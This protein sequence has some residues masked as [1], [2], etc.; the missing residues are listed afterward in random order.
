M[1][2]LVN[3]ANASH[4]QDLSILQ[5]SSFNCFLRIQKKHKNKNNSL[6]RQ[7]NVNEIFLSSTSK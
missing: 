7:R 6:A 3:H 2:E 1:A 5:T 4:C